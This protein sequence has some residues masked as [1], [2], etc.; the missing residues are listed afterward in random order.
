MFFLFLYRKS[1]LKYVNNSSHGFLDLPQKQNTWIDGDFC[2]SC[3]IFWIATTKTLYNF[4]IF[5]VLNVTTCTFGIGCSEMTMGCACKVENFFFFNG[6]EFLERN[7]IETKLWQKLNNEQK[8]GTATRQQ[9]YCR[10]CYYC[11]GSKKLQTRSWCR[12]KKVLF[13]TSFVYIK[14]IDNKPERTCFQL[15]RGRYSWQVIQT[16]KYFHQRGKCTIRITDE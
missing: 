3:Y 7:T 10:F 16:I 13:A 8:W 11:Y 9:G 6:S 5:T 15:Y 2:F 4:D 1:T 14:C 12:L